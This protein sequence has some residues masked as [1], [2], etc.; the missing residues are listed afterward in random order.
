MAEAIAVALR[1]KPVADL[2]VVL[3]DGETPWP[4]RRPKRPVI[5][6]LICEEGSRAAAHVPGWATAVNIPID[7]LRGP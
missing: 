2:I 1:E 3:T 6:G 7:D 4:G 5:V